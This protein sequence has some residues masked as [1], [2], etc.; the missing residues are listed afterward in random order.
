MGDRGRWISG[1]ALTLSAVLI[2]FAGCSAGAD[3][4]TPVELAGGTVAR[5]VES[6][7][8][9]AKRID[10]AAE[11]P[12]TARLRHLRKET[13]H[14][15]FSG[16]FENSKPIL[17]SAVF[18]Q[19]QVVREESHYLAGEKTILVKIVRWWDVEDAKQ[20]P[21]PETRQSF[22][23]RDG[24]TIRHVI[25]TVS[26]PPKSRTDEVSRP[27][28]PLSQRWRAIAQVLAGSGS[29]AAVTNALETFPEAAVPER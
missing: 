7:R 26:T 28:G 11:S 16:V 19:G 5:E 21:E 22:Y 17:V 6:I 24:R 9:E 12:D 18:S 1:L 10:A 25:E 29:V 4:Q 20:A 15:R 27:S 14:W 3:Q 23:I 2:Q 13:P 8:A